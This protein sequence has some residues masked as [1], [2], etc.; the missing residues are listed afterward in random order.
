MRKRKTLL[1]IDIETKSL[2][3]TGLDFERKSLCIISSVNTGM[4]E[5]YLTNIAANSAVHLE[6]HTGS[7]NNPIQDAENLANLHKL[8][9]AVLVP[10]F[11]GLL[12][13]FESRCTS[14]QQDEIDELLQ[15][16]QRC[17]KLTIEALPK[18]CQ[19]AILSLHPLQRGYPMM[20]TQRERIIRNFNQVLHEIELQDGRVRVINSEVLLS[21]IGYLQGLD[22][23]MYY[24]AKSPYKNIFLEDL[25]TTIAKVFNHFGDN[26]LK[27]LALDFDNTLWGGVLGEDGVEGVDLNPFDFPGSIFFDVQH[28]L[29]ELK[30]LGILLVALSKNNEADAL[31]MLKKN[32]NNILQVDDFA[33]MK[34][35]WNDKTENLKELATELAVSLD[36]FAVLDDSV[37]ECEEIRFRLP[38]VKVFQ[39]PEALELYPG[40][41]DSVR[42]LFLRG[43][44]EDVDDKTHQYQLRQRGIDDKKSF[45]TH[46]EYLNSLN[47][48]VTFNI[49][50]RDHIPRAAEMTLKTNQFNLTTIRRSEEEIRSLMD[51]SE[52]TVITYEVSDKYGTHGVVGL[53]ILDF[54]S[55]TCLITDFM[56]SCRVLGKDV[57][58][59]MLEVCA[60]EA[61]NRGCSH[62]V[63]RYHSSQKNSQTRNFYHLEQT[64]LK[65]MRDG[66]LNFV[67]DLSNWRTIKPDWIKVENND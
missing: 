26:V 32:P 64:L 2:Y 35:N 54:N 12:P 47:L 31:E 23:R 25:S 42:E 53:S 21:S 45:L 1:E 7:Y 5:K 43:R 30:R 61:I 20:S 16:F 14:I 55:N 39:V 4:I 38:Q 66:S 48:L 11:D 49:D 50:R 22:L 9:F 36:S 59:A 46:S 28:R 33:S 44:R 56:I 51:S 29:K 17:W 34:I 52:K 24:R 6:I 63:G 10:F 3:E 41:V 57:E 60:Q 15:D 40:L 18:N 58:F 62:L 19:I 27:V 37:Y 13:S 65:D 67:T 8:D